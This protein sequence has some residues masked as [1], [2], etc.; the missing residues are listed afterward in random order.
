[1]WPHIETENLVLEDEDDEYDLIADALAPGAVMLPAKAVEL[2]MLEHGISVFDL[3]KCGGVV[4]EKE[5]M[6]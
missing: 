5:I 6:Q 2:L 1:M 4:R 3:A